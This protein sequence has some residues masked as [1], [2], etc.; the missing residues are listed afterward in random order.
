MHS[1]KRSSDRPRQS[2][3]WVGCCSGPKWGRW[4]RAVIAMLWGFDV[5]KMDIWH[6]YTYI[7]CP[8]VKRLVTNLKKNEDQVQSLGAILA[9][10]SRN[11]ILKCLQYICPQAQTLNFLMSPLKSPISVSGS[12]AGPQKSAVTSPPLLSWWKFA[13]HN[14]FHFHQPNVCP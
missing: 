1:R 5:N 13:L 11:I 2:L 12:S 7:W 14:S 4:S 3:A 8:I 10:L 6:V 9:S